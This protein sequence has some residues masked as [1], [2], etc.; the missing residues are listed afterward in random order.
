MLESSPILQLGELSAFSAEVPD[1]TLSPP[2]TSML[3]LQ[4][5][6]DIWLGD[7]HTQSMYVFSP[8]LE[9][10]RAAKLQE[11]VV[12]AV[13]IQNTA[14][15]TSMGS[16][17]PTDQPTGML[18]ALPSKGS[19]NVLIRGLQRPVHTSYGDLDGDGLSDLVICEYAKWTGRL[20]WGKN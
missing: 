6:G 1:Y 13:D 20:A 11:G 19:A 15:I 14:L 5:S 16:F 4:A 10:T 3:S 8:E 7:A 2:S 12:H 17:S 9:L 18:V